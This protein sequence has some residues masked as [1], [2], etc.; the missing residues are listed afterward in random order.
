MKVLSPIKL[1]RITTPSELP[2]SDISFLYFKTDGKLYKKDPSGIETL[3]EGGG[4]YP[5]TVT[6]DNPDENDDSTQGHSIGDRWVN[7]E[8][9]SEF[10]STSVAIGAAVWK[11]TTSNDAYNVY[12]VTGPPT[13][14]DDSTQGYIVGDRW[15]DLSAA[16]YDEYILLDGTTGNANWHLA[17]AESSTVLTGDVIITGDTII[18]GD[19]T[20]SGRLAFDNA[21]TPPPMTSRTNNYAPTGI[22]TA[23]M[24]RLSSSSNVQLTGLQQPSPIVNQMLYVINVGDNRIAILDNSAFS[25]AENRF[26]INTTR[27]IQNNEGILLV[28]D[29]DSLTWRIVASDV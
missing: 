17:T 4:N 3:V 13:V 20:F 8:T 6:I 14:N 22:E 7:T 21:V 11:N 9:H 18:G 5:L 16:P 26:T 23:N 29:K 15:L 10:I 25:D 1:Q 19:T 12:Q 24:L 28:Y 2:S 27:R